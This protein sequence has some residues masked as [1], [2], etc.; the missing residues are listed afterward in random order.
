MGYIDDFAHNQ[1]HYFMLTTYV[2]IILQKQLMIV[3]IDVYHDST[4]GQ[5]KSV[6]GFIA[7]TNRYVQLM[8]Y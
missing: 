5:K 3:G 2:A 8:L 7:S 6:V 4:F 1:V